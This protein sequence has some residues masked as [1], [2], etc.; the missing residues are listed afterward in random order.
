MPDDIK[1]KKLF[2]AQKMVLDLK[3]L[4]RFNL[5]MYNTLNE[6]PKNPDAVYVYNGKKYGQPKFRLKN[7]P[8]TDLNPVSDAFNFERDEKTEEITLKCIIEVYRDEPDVIPL[9]IIKPSILLSFE[10]A[11]RKVEKPLTITQSLSC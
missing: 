11:G 8:A 10:S 4:L 3:P 5:V 6:E 7:N 1:G 2:T 9:S